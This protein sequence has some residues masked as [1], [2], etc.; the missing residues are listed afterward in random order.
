M[1][2]IT[3]HSI[4]K[5]NHKQ[6]RALADLKIGQLIVRNFRLVENDSG[7]LFM[8]VPSEV[9]KDGNWYPTVSIVNDN[10]S[11]FKNAAEKIILDAYKAE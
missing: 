3:L 5:T 6:T 2:N 8:S 9:N 11:K 10:D 4:R 1:E 7:E